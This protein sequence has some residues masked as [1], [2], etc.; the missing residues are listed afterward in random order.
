MCCRS[1]E[2][3]VSSKPKKKMKHK[4]KPVTADYCVMEKKIK[5]TEADYNN[6]EM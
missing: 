2:P 5:E 1:E 6:K 3:D 4:I